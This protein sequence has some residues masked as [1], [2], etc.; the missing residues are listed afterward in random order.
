[1]VLGVGVG[2]LSKI[3]VAPSPG[4]L[5]GNAC[6]SVAGLPREAR[7]FLKTCTTP[8]SFSLQLAARSILLS[9]YP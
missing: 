8:T 7:H 2:G 9:Y 5:A 1:M 3:W 4:S 6:A